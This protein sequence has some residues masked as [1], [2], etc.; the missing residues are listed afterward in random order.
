MKS[1][2]SLGAIIVLGGACRIVNQLKDSVVGKNFDI[3]LNAFSDN[4]SDLQTL[5]IESKCYIPKQGGMDN[6]ERHYSTEEKQYLNYNI[7]EVLNHEWMAAFILSIEDFHN[8]GNL[9]EYLDYMTHIVWNQEIRVK[10]L[11]VCAHEDNEDTRNYLEDIKER[12][13]GVTIVKHRSNPS[14]QF[15]IEQLR[16]EAEQR[17]VDVARG[18]IQACVIHSKLC[19]DMNDVRSFFKEQGSKEVDFFSCHGDINDIL[20]GCKTYEK[21]ILPNKY[22][23]MIIKVNE[24]KTVETNSDELLSVL[25]WI[26]EKIQ[27]IKGIEFKLT[28]ITDDIPENEFHIYFYSKGIM[29]CQ[30]TLERKN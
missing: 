6:Y 27:S 1:N 21:E 26:A 25:N 23:L 22:I 5:D 14:N 19:F 18:I 3:S 30:Y 9:Q 12:Y 20:Q 2:N 29:T 11:I 8:E 24:L 17:T 28:I 4:I 7:C 15:N 13:D 10:Y 16:Q